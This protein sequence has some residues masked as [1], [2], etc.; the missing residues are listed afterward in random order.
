[1]A[2][3]HLLPRYV[4]SGYVSQEQAGRNNM[5]RIAEPDWL[6]DAWYAEYDFNHHTIIRGHVAARDGAGLLREL[7]ATLTRLEVKHAATG[8]AGAWLWK[9]FAAFRTVTLYTPSWPG[10]GLLADLGFNEGAR[11]SNTWLVVP[12][13]VGVFAGQT[14][15][16]GIPCVSAAQVYVDLKAQPERAEEARAELRRSHLSW[17][18]MEQKGEN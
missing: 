16:D 1:M 18:G 4:E 12:D 8:L 13:D 10:A 17:P 3:H 6:L 5:Y 9:S 2:I 7:S 15:R 14:D 11:G